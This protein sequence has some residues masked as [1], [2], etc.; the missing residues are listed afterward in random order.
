MKSFKN[1]GFVYTQ[2]KRQFRSVL[3]TIWSTSPKLS[4]YIFLKL[5]VSQLENINCNEMRV[6]HGRKITV[7]SQCQSN[8]L[9]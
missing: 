4:K 7:H 3:L 6:L 5:L 1:L 8:F 2:M 9:K